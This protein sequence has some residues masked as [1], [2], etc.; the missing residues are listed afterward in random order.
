MKISMIGAGNISGTLG[1][2]W[3]AQGHE[4]V[5]GVREPQA[6]KVQALLAQSGHGA[7]AVPLSE[8]VLRAEV[9]VFA[10]PGR[11]MGEVVGQLEAQLN[12][13]LLIDTTNKV[14]QM[15]LH[16]LD[17][18]RRAAPDS[19]LFRAFSTL[20]WENFANPEINS[21]QTDLFYCGDEGAGQT[22]VHDLITA[23]GLRPI[24]LGDLEQADYLDAL[25]QLWFILALKQG[26][27]RHL[28]LKMLTD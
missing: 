6:E 8:S 21:V 7:T 27:G 4:V 9:V 18:L 26:R 3:A 16:S 10:V 13:K 1:S 5:F 17:V 23:I 25:T 19:L 20:G 15:P 2:K 14:G 22:A 24:Y 12:G 28:A 11:V